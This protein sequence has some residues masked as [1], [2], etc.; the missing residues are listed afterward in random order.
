MSGA[1]KSVSLRFVLFSLKLYVVQNSSNEVIRNV[2]GDPAAAHRAGCITSRNAFGVSIPQPADILI[3]CSF[4]Y[5]I[6]F[7][8]CE[9]L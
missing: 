2:T 7:W 6:D 3:S 1:L 4:P 9:K 8:R 5:D